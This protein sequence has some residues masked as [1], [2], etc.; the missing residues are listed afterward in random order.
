MNQIEVRLDQ[1][2]LADSDE[3]VL[4]SVIDTIAQARDGG[5]LAQDWGLLEYI[6]DPVM[7]VNLAA[8]AFVEIGGLRVEIIV[9]YGTDTDPHRYLGLA[10]GSIVGLNLPGLTGKRFRLDATG[11]D[12]EDTLSLSLSEEL[13]TRYTAVGPPVPPVDPPSVI[14]RNARRPI[15]P[16]INMLSSTK[17]TVQWVSRGDRFPGIGWRYQIT[18]QNMLDLMASGAV[19]NEVQTVDLPFAVPGHEF[20][21]R[22]GWYYTLRVSRRLTEHTVSRRSWARLQAPLTLPTAEFTQLGYRGITDADPTGT[23]EAHW[24]CLLYKS[25]SPRD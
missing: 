4:P 1:S 23:G 20:P 3:H 22:L 6:T 7:A 8:R 13:A 2:R 5:Q 10:P 12:E 15:A 25:P 16:Q 19:W 24:T 14:G 21:L 17:G 9:P 11:P 18:E